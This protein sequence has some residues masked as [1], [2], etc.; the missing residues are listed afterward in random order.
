MTLHGTILFPA[1]GSELKDSS[2]NWSKVL[3]DVTAQRLTSRFVD[4]LYLNT[5]RP[6]HGGA[7]H[8]TNRERRFGNARLA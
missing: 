4:P 6:K 1:R 2:K 5:E 7:S 3:G 8:M